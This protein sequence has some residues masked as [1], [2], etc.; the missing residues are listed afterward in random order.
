MTEF[1]CKSVSF[2]TIIL[3]HILSNAVRSFRFGMVP[4]SLRSNFSNSFSNN[5]KSWALQG[6]E[7]MEW[8]S[9]IRSDKVFSPTWS[10][11]YSWSMIYNSRIRIISTSGIIGM[12]SIGHIFRRMVTNSS[13]RRKP[14]LDG[15]A[16]V[17]WL[18]SSEIRNSIGRN[19][20]GVGGPMVFI[21]FSG[22]L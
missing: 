21:I 16:S 1:Y 8:I 6:I 2:S 19:F 12:P 4:V 22:G 11:R 18:V 20:A 10:F 5:N 9:G 13:F 3:V 7:I 17:N 14:V 15:S